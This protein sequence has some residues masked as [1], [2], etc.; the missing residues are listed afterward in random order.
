MTDINIKQLGLLIQADQSGAFQKILQ[1]KVHAEKLSK[2]KEMLKNKLRP[3]QM[4]T[5]RAIIVGLSS[6]HELREIFNHLNVGEQ[7]DALYYIIQENVAVEKPHDS[8]ENYVFRNY[9]DILQ[10]IPNL[11][12]Q[13]FIANMSPRGVKKILTALVKFQLRNKNRDVYNAMLPYIDKE[14]LVLV[15]PLLSVFPTLLEDI[16]IAHNLSEIALS[17][18]VRK[19]GIISDTFVQKDVPHMVDDALVKPVPTMR[20]LTETTPYEIDLKSNQANNF[21]KD[22]IAVLRQYTDD[23]I[24][25]NA[26]LKQLHAWVDVQSH[27]VKQKILYGLL[28]GFIKDNRHQNVPKTIDKLNKIH[29]SQG[30]MHSLYTTLM[31]EG[32]TLFHYKYLKSG[33]DS[34]LSKENSVMFNHIINVNPVA[35]DD[36]QSL[37]QLYEQVD[38]LD[39]EMSM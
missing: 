17:A 6:T 30:F 26:L 3:D 29:Q 23:G 9:K 12:E 10:V 13:Q 37:K 14:S 19:A 4:H 18:W 32:L 36:M 15:A 34:F 38:P 31:N 2:I 28:E 25:D 33:C 24:Y 1:E 27:D 11:F 8:A 5:L 7:E 21:I 16:K 20:L 39:I 35:F 22:S